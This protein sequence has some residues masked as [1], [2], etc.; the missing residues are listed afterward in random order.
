MR[1]V[2][3][4]GGLTD[5]RGMTESVRHIWVLSLCHVTMVYNTI[6]QLTGAA[7]KST[8]GQIDTKNV[9]LRPDLV[10]AVPS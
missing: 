8:A 3:S 1:S 7:A 6:L 10:V 5:G 9:Q 2:K 4:R